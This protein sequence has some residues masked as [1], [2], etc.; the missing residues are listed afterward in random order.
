MELYLSGNYDKVC[1]HESKKVTI[2]LYYKHF[3]I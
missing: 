3:M 2:Y 1:I